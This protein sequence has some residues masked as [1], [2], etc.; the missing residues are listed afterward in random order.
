MLTTNGSLITK[1]S[2]KDTPKGFSTSSTNNYSTGDNDMRWMYATGS[3]FGY[4][5][6]KGTYKIEIWH[7]GF[8]LYKKSFKII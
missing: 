8:M 4:F 6:S 1:G 5:W 2:F 3:A 7:N